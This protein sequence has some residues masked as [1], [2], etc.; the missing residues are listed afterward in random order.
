[1]AHNRATAPSALSAL[2][3]FFSLLPLW[4]KGAVAF[5]SVLFCLFAGLAIARLRDKPSV[6]V[7][8]PPAQSQ[9]ELNALVEQRVQAELLR[10][11]NAEPPKPVMTAD[12]S[13]RENPARRIANRGELAG[14]ATNQ[15]ARRPL[16]KTEREQLA[17]DL[18]LLSGKNDSELDLL[19]DRINQ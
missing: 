10:I 8:G 12:N 6:V 18:R 4:L 1:M 3:E 7:E 11:R 14:S 19:E 9:Q 5:A 15:K 13:S 17:A 16:S 2:R